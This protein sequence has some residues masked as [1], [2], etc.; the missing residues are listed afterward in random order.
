MNKHQIRTI[1]EGDADQ[2]I[3]LWNT[4]W[5]ATYGPSLGND[6]L[7]HMLGELALKKTS[8]MLP[9]NGERGICLVDGDEIVGSVIVAARGSKAYLW[10]LYIEPRHQ[11]RGLGSKLLAASSDGLPE[12]TDIEV[13]VL[14][15]STSAISFYKKHG[16]VEAETERTEL[17]G[18]VIASTAVMVA[19]A[20]DI[21][22][23][24]GSS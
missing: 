4:T 6:S 19:C 22:A 14:L 12:E 18:G 16:F 5:T 24:L 2:L 13:R 7:A 21:G 15:T 10:G 9:G 11:R 3:A 8:G 17:P 20:A 23:V 1:V